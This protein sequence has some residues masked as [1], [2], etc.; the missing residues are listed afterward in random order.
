M[1]TEIKAVLISE[2]S[3]IVDL[4]NFAVLKNKRSKDI[5]MQKAN[6]LIALKLLTDMDIEQLVVYAS[7]IDMLFDCIRELKKKKF[8]EVYDD[9]KE[10]K[11]YIANP[12]IK[13][14]REMIEITSRIGADFGFTPVAR[15]RLKTEPVKA[16]DPFDEMMNKFNN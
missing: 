6:Q 2:I 8:T 11:G 4:K 16:K 14:Y 12:Y 13:L 10:L 3:E 7:S 5:F 1:K 9:S 15:L